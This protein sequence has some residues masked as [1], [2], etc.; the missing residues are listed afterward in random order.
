MKRALVYRGDSPWCK[1]TDDGCDPRECSYAICVKRRLLPNG[2]CGLAI[3]RRTTEG[4]RP[5]EFMTTGIR[6]RG[7][8]FRKLGEKEVF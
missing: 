3:K 4:V 8:A 5:E 6:V 1:L 7:K 2:T